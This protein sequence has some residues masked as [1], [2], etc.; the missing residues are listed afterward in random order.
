MMNNDDLERKMG[1]IVDQQAKFAVDIERL[2]EAQIL[3]AQAIQKTDEVVTR[4]AD[5]TN[6]GFKDTT[7]KIN[8]LVDSQLRTD[9]QIRSLR[10]SQKKTEE[11][12]NKTNESLKKTDEKFRTLLERLDRRSDNGDNTD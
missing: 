7:A 10:E 9:E 6:E 12:L 4:L 1:F 2:H 5:V 8:A 11:S 3:T